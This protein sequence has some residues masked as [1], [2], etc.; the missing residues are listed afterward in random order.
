MATY[1]LNYLY[2]LDQNGNSSNAKVDE[3]VPNSAGTAAE[4][5][6]DGT[7]TVGESF[8]V[9]FIDGTTQ[10]Q[11]GGTYT[12]VGQ[13]SPFPGF[14]A[15]DVNGEFFLFTN[16]TIKTGTQ[17]NG[18]DDADATIDSPPLTVSVYAD[19]TQTD[20]VALFNGA[21]A[22]SDALAGAT[23]GQ[24]IAVDD[25]V[26]LGDVGA[27]SV[28]VGGLTIIANGPFDASFSFTG[29]ASNLALSGTASMDV[30]GTAGANVIELLGGPDS[31][32]Y[33]LDGGTGTDTLQ[34]DATTDLR[35]MTIAGFETLSLDSASTDIVSAAITM[36]QLAGFTDIVGRAGFSDRLGVDASG[37]DVDLSGLVL[38][39]I[40]VTSIHGENDGLD[41]VLV[42]SSIRDTFT[43]DG[44]DQASGGA[45]DDRYNV[46]SASAVVAENSGE[47]LDI[48][49]STLGAYTLTDNVEYLQLDGAGSMDGTGN[50]GDNKITGGAGA[51][52]LSGLDGNDSLLGG[53]DN[54][55]LLGGI[56]ND[57]LQGGIGA[58]RLDGGA[59]QDRLTGGLG[60]DTFVLGSNLVADF[61]RFNDFEAGTD[62]AEIAGSVFGM[63]AGALDPAAFAATAN[64]QAT[65]ALHRLIYNTSNGALYFDAD[66][67]G[68]GA[69]IQVA[70]FLGA[71][72]LASTDFIVA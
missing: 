47:G 36:A 18:F 38:D 56:G 64:G 5:V 10:A 24:A 50:A 72:T 60:A 11:Y 31:G 37:G 15:E 43:M 17:L 9:S 62:T 26:A 14:I 32:A 57:N 20:L 2:L 8:V 13:A 3:L 49:K 33:S 71:P 45:G 67:S 44:A 52:V 19:A 40:D 61:D 30:L 12:Y 53:D 22:F 48:V 23:A 41:G 28:T 1:S 68:A 42:G 27:Q 21:S 29:G 34:V 54:D 39:Q 65:T 7:A 70:S 4:A 25:P 63:A 58:D 69:R 46:S 55:E 51:N 16:S 66:G 35:G 59:G 6:N